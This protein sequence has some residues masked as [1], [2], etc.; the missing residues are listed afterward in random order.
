MK[1]LFLLIVCFY[2]HLLIKLRQWWLLIHLL[3][4]IVRWL[5]FVLTLRILFVLFLSFLIL[6]FKL[7]FSFLLPLLNLLIIFIILLLLLNFLIIHTLAGNPF[8]IEYIMRVIGDPLRMV[9]LEGQTEALAWPLVTYY[10]WTLILLI[11]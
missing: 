1:W 9:H 6:Y 8:I 4:H 5:F 2:M 10:V 11:S 7:T 3:N